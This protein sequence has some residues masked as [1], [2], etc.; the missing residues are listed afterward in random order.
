MK[1]LI[2]FGKA[3]GIMATAMGILFLVNV[4][5]NIF[6]IIGWSVAITIII[7]GLIYLT[8]AYY[9]ESK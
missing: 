9:K 1:L 7:G 2:A 4:L 3:L 5:E 8:I 6:P